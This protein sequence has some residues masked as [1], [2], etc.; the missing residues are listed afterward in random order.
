MKKITFLALIFCGISSF[1]QYD[2][3][4]FNGE[5]LDANSSGVWV[6]T[7][8]KAENIEGSYRLFKNDFHTGIITTKE[9]KKYKVPGLN[10]NLKSDQLEVKISQDSVYAFNTASI[11]EVE[12]GDNK[13]KALFDP[14]KYRPT[15]YEV[16]GSFDNQTILK[17]RSVKVKTGIVNPMTQQKQTPDTFVQEQTYFVTNKKG[18]L[19]E[20]KLKK[21]T[22]L[23]LFDD[24]ADDVDDYVSENDLSYK[25][26]ADLKKIFKFYNQNS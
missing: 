5:N 14:E 4:V 10:Y 11:V 16:I 22:I 25:E 18:G 15:F 21:R 2:V 1:A 19:D 6:V 26:D 23:K 9:G 13:F 3:T 12:F 20:L 24:S 17:H 8:P 7:K